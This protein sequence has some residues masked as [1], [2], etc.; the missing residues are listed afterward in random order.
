[1]LPIQ[2][3]RIGGAGNM[4]PRGNGSLTVAQ[5]LTSSVGQNGIIEGLD[6]EGLLCDNSRRHQAIRR[7]FSIE[8]NL[9]WLIQK[10]ALFKM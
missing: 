2:D 6:T 9:Y 7:D 4:L 10:D 8:N 3:P 5:S 1:M